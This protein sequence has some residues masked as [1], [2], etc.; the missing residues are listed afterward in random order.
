MLRNP[1][2]SFGKQKENLSEKQN[3]SSVRGDVGLRVFWSCD[4]SADDSNDNAEHSDTL[5]ISGRDRTNSAT[6][7][8]GVR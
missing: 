6:R 5:A 8:K 7:A 3:Y 2:T 1:A 4:T